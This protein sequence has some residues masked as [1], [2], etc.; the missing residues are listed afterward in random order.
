MAVATLSA[1]FE[2]ASIERLRVQSADPVGVGARHARQL[3]TSWTPHTNL[4]EVRRWSLRIDLGDLTEY[5]AL[6]AVWAAS[7]GGTL[8]V[9]WTPPDE[10][11]AIDVLIAEYRPVQAG[12]GRFS[13]SMTLEEDF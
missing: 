10:S 12:P 9:E 7:K 2:S 1:C 8:P 3:N 4:P 5:L 6:E 11:T 13:V